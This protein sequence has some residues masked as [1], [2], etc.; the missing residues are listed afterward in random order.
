MISK[1]YLSLY[2]DWVFYNAAGGKYI[3]GHG[4]GA[5]AQHTYCIDISWEKVLSGDLVFY[6]DDVHVG[7]VG[8]RDE[9]GNLLIIH[10]ASGTNNVVITNIAVFTSIGRLAYY[11]DNM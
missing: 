2:V 11:G 10:C 3:I 1:G 4:G 6:P 5:H 9:S 8:G 7:I